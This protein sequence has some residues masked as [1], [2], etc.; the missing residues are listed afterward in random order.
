M[1]QITILFLVSVSICQ[2]RNTTTYKEEVLIVANTHVNI[3]EW[4]IQEN[5]FKNELYQHVQQTITML[6]FF[7]PISC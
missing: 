2:N 5:M 4:I 3:F 1:R 7:I 6:K